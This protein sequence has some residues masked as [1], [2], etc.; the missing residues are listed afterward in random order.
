M[1]RTA[2]VGANGYWAGNLRRV[3]DASPRFKL[4]A[5]VDPIGCRLRSLDEAA[6]LFDLDAVVVATP[7]ST[8][9]A[10]GLEALERGYHVLVEKPL[11]CSVSDGEKLVAAARD[12]NRVLMVDTTYCYSPRVA[13][14][15]TLLRLMGPPSYWSSTR[16]HNGGPGDVS[17]VYDLVVHDLAVIAALVPE[18]SPSLV[19][20][21]GTAESG[22]LQITG[23]G[24]VV[25]LDFARD[26]PAKIRL[27]TIH[28]PQGAISWDDT[29]IVPLRARM[30]LEIPWVDIP[31]LWDSEPL[32]NV[33]GDFADAIEGVPTRFPARFPAR[34]TGEFALHGLRIIQAAERSFDSGRPEP[35]R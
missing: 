1:I 3:L 32:A 35:V 19:D 22:Q 7:A 27:T 29:S 13:M 12:A 8:H 10:I 21:I 14:I 2:L 34:S 28:T 4:V 23:G 15:S 20:A 18:W 24:P 25:Y 30:P 11:A 16:V 26:A 9:A 5:E 31:I 33:V 17:S 6:V